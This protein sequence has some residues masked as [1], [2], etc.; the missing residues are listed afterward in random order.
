M[1]RTIRYVTGAFAL[2]LVLPLA[3]ACGDDDVTSPNADTLAL[4]DLLLDDISEAEL[5][6][7]GG[8]EDLSDDDKAAIRAALQAARDQIH[9]VFRQVRAGEMTREEARAELDRIHNALMETL[10]QYLTDEQLDRFTNR[11][12]NHRPGAPGGD[13]PELGLTDDQLAQIHELKRGAREFF[14]S[15][16]EQ[17]E[18]GAITREEAREM[19]RMKAQET[20]AAFCAILTADQQAQVPFCS[21]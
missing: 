10:S 1:A 9:S 15:L 4:G 13:R 19:I 3:A 5:F 7:S 2:A 12:M 17:V 14:Q 20:R 18:S 6:A 21:S 16:R 8:L 11:F